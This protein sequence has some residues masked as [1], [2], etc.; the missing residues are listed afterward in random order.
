MIFLARR[1]NNIFEFD[2][3]MPNVLSVPFFVDTVY[4]FWC[5]LT[6]VVSEK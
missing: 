5:W 3:I 4:V 1:Y 6:R 2:K